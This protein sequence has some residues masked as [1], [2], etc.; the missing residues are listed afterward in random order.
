M[1]DDAWDIYEVKTG[2]SVKDVNLHDLAFQVHVYKAAGLKIRRSHL[3]E[4]PP[5]SWTCEA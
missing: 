4:L 1:G 2:A 3:V 5:I